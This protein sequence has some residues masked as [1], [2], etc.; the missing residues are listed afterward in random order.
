M[1]LLWAAAAATQAQTPAPTLAR[2]PTSPQA[3][4]QAQA[5][6]ASAPGG[7]NWLDD[8]L[9][10]NITRVAEALA[11]T[12]SAGSPGQP[13]LR[14]EVRLGTLDSRLKLA[15]CAKVQTYWPTGQRPQGD[16]R[17]GLRCVDGPKRWNVYLPVTILWWGQALVA[18]AD[19]PAGTKLS[20]VHF[21]QVEVD[22][23]ADRDPALTDANLVIG[24]PLARA[25]PSGQTLRR[26]DLKLR[27]WVRAGDVVRLV[28][29]NAGFQVVGEARALSGAQEG[30][31]V[32]ART[33]N[34]RIVQG[35]AVGE[36]QISVPL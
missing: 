5:Q 9:Q 24:R 20:A 17:I 22:L 1:G 21:R 25:V 4:A 34:G 18:A 7:G 30:Q 36:R 10:T 3:Q 23:A 32:R 35:K 8:S 16:A 27:T 33:E 14:M 26:G 6:P 19:L 15:P 11:A 28:A 31:Q 29:G 2:L 12:A 13:P